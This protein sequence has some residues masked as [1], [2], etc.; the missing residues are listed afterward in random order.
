[1]HAQKWKM[2]LCETPP[3]YKWRFELQTGGAN[4]RNRRITVFSW[5]SV[6]GA[7]DMNS[8]KFIR[9]SQYLENLSEL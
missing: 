8:S 3:Y 9:G 6:R 2:P 5:P 1:M 4:V 7:A